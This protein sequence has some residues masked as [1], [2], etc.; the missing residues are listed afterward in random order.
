MPTVHVQSGAGVLRAGG[1]GGGA[2]GRERE[3]ALANL[4]INKTQ[5]LT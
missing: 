3:E 1:S 2:E 5:M 4:I